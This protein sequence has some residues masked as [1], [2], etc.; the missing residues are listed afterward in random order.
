MRSEPDL[1]GCDGLEGVW[2][3]GDVTVGTDFVVGL[4]D[5]DF[6]GGD[7]LEVRGEDGD[8]SEEPI[9]AGQSV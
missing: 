9:E 8:G 1:E 5:S 7:V 6:E 3:D 4:V 2:K